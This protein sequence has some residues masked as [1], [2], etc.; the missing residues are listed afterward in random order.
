MTETLQLRFQCDA[1]LAGND[2]NKRSQTLILAYLGC[3]L[4]C[5][6]S[7]DQGS[8]STSTAESE[9]KA[10]NHALRGE[11]IANRGISTLMGWTQKTTFIEV[12]NKACVDASNPSLSKCLCSQ[13]LLPSLRDLLP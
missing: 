7:T 5:Y 13:L 6:C 2:V 11:L 10:V 9:I 12:D 1:D 4:I 3:S 8:V